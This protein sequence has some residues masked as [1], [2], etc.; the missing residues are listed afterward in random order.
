MPG[1]R[2]EPGVI[3]VYVGLLLN[4]PNHFG[5][6]SLPASLSLCLF[7]LDPDAER[8]IFKVTPSHLR[9]IQIGCERGK[10]LPKVTSKGDPLCVLL[11]NQ[12]SPKHPKELC[13]GTGSEASAICRPLVL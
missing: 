8:G 13:M 9:D 5:E 7:S 6:P 3:R 4:D 1:S 2:A 12:G 10:H 11:S